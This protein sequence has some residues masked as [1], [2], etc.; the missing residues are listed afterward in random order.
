MYVTSVTI[1]DTTIGV[2]EAYTG[3][4]ISPALIEDLIGRLDG[5]RYTMV[6]LTGADQT[7]LAIGGHARLGLVVYEA[8]AD[9]SSYTVL[10]PGDVVAMAAGRVRTG[11][12]VDAGKAVSAAREWAMTGRLAPGMVW[13]TI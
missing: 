6:T 10:S 8:S 2:E 12:L 13:Q 4:Q 5:E 1:D 3:R 9:S 11:D 7:R